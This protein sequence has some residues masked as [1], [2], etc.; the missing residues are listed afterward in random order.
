[1]QPFPGLLD[2]GVGKFWN[3]GIAE[4]CNHAVCRL[5][6]QKLGHRP[7]FKDPGRFDTG[8]GKPY[9]RESVKF[10]QVAE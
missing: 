9:N 4:F 6:T 8:V 7:R 10:C 5:R 3:L 2:I 1:M